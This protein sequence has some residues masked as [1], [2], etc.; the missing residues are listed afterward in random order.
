MVCILAFQIAEIAQEFVG[1]VV[2]GLALVIELLN[3]KQ[4]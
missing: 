3:T 2:I 1:I 4:N